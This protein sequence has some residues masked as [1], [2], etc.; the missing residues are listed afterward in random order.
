[1]CRCFCPNAA[2]TAHPICSHMAI[3]A[4]CWM[5]RNEYHAEISAVI[6]AQL[7]E[8]LRGEIVG[9]RARS[10]R[11]KALRRFRSDQLALATIGLLGDWVKES[12]GTTPVC[13]N[14]NN[15]R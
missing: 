12:A 9:V 8:R 6:D 2:E 10:L 14:L 7:E 3:A 5:I 1:S 4:C 11:L 15:E 13:R